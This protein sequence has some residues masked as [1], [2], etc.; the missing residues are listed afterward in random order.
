[1]EDINVKKIIVENLKYKYPLTEHLALNDI[2]FD[3]EEGEFIGIIG[4]TNQESLHFARLLLGLF[5]TFIKEPMVDVYWL[6]G[7]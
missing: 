6:M 7:W 2:S 4:K 1:M 3:V 5:H